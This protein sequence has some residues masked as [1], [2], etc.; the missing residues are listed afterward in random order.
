MWYTADIGVWEKGRVIK[1]KAVTR[2]AALK[3]ASK[4]AAREDVDVVQL[5]TCGKNPPKGPLG[6]GPGNTIWDE[7]NGWYRNRYFIRKEN[8]GH[9]AP[10]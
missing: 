3:R 1:F 7:Y 9:V 2:Q 6:R 5:R 8:V 10:R 4:I